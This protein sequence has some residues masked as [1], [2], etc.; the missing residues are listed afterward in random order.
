ML[1][2]T[3]FNLLLLFKTS[4]CSHYFKLKCDKMS[5]PCHHIHWHHLQKKDCI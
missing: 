3:K 2:I 4:G 1:L 5:F